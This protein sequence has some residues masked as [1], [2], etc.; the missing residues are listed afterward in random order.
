MRCVGVVEEAVSFV[1]QTAGAAFS[2]KA[3]AGRKKS[4]NAGC[5]MK[6]TQPNPLHLII[7]SE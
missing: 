2:L 3:C 5:K 6:T 1:E 4:E 7:L